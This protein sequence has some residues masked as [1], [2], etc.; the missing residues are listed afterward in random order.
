MKL[1]KLTVGLVVAG[2]S[3]SNIVNATTVEYWTTQ[4]QSD[5]LQTIEI[6]ADVFEALNPAKIVWLP[7]ATT[8]V[9][10][11]DKLPV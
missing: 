8:V 10:P 11:E 7:I 1:N 3:F 2:L 5:R 9:S 6:M 4:T